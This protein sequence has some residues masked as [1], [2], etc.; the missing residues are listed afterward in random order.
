MKSTFF[1]SHKLLLLIFLTFTSV[2]LQAQSNIAFYPLEE[3]F[4]AFDYNPAFLNSPE[5]YTFSIF[6]L[7]G[8]NIVTNNQA[9]LR[10]AVR[11][12]NSGVISETYYKDL[13]ERLLDK[14]SFHEALE[15]TLLNF[16]YG[17]KKGFF[18]FRIK[19]RQFMDAS[20]HGEVTNFIFKSEL[21][22]AAIDKV[23][24]FPVKAAHYREYSVGYSYTSPDKRLS[25]GV[26]GKLYF[27]KFAF[28]SDINGSIA[29]QENDY[30]LQTRGMAYI[31]FPGKTI[32]SSSGDTYTVDLSNANIKNYLF[33]SG[34]PGAGV[35]LG[36][37]YKIN[38]LLSF[39][40]S[41]VDLGRINWKE[42]VNSRKMD[43]LFSLPASS[44][45]L[46]RIAGVP[47]ITKTSDYAYSDVF[48]F[49][50]LQIDSSSFHTGLP[51]TIYAGL[52]YMV[53]TGLSVSITDRYV[54]MKHL[55]YNSLSLAANMELSKKISASMGY[56]I[57]G[58]SY[59]NIPFALLFKHSYGQV[60]LGTDNLFFIFSPE[61]TDFAAL[62]FGACF[63]LFT[64]RNLLLKRI[65]YLPFYQPRKTIKSRRNGLLIKALN[66][67]K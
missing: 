42:N 51:T 22:S 19:E 34:N 18:N 66:Q 44:Y 1:H 63:Y 6:P 58:N 30:G 49:S 25:A 15:S 65:E 54:A 7:A 39:S 35:D 33:N 11:K 5:K 17:S 23:Q 50:S 10:E 43:T 14:S 36:I 21:S 60:Y 62:S 13:F 37:V 26:R 56:S 59:F 55:G 20:I 52:K 28:N 61:K 8:M 9:I 64:H 47:T 24:Y 2:A 53:N 48:N 4:N 32:K 29:S 16:T 67:D 57:I 12:S 45:E 27:G 46:S 3:Q 31:S 38:P 40:I 41:A